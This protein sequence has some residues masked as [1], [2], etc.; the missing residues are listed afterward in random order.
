MSNPADST[1]RGPV[2]YFHFAAVFFGFILTAAGVISL[3]PGIALVG[4]AVLALGF[5]YFLFQD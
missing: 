2:D 1:D 3:S 5:V 4:V